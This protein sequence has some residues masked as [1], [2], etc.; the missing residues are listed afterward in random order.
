MGFRGALVDRAVRIRKSSTGRRVEGT[1]IFEPNESASIRVR[2]DVKAAGEEL[3][4]GRVLTEPTPVLLVFRRDMDGTSL[5]WK[6]S[7]RILV[8]SAQL[9]VHEYEVQ[10]E[11]VPMR[12]KRRV[13]GWELTL[14][15][16]E[17]NL[18]TRTVVP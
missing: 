2:L 14:R 16:T 13:L 3:A 5:D 9:G 15:R 11:P 1:T 7:D 12:R 10:G 8:T 4:D 17:E 6:A 18:T